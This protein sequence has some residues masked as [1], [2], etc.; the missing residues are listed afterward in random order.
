MMQTGRRGGRGAEAEIRGDGERGVRRSRREGEKERGIKEKGRESVRQICAHELNGYDV[1]IGKEGDEGKERRRQRKE[2]KVTDFDSRTPKQSTC[3]K[4]KIGQYL[5][6]GTEGED[7]MMQRN[8]NF[9]VK[10]W[11]CYPCSVRS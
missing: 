7:N 1:P 5:S 3:T 10:E 8:Q 9:P 6:T 11:F 4:Q 2:K